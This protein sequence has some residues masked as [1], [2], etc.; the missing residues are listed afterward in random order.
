MYSLLSCQLSILGMSRQ[1]KEGYVQWYKSKCQLIKI[2]QL[3]EI[4]SKEGFPLSIATFT[5]QDTG[6]KF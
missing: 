6:S 3:G 5:L 1:V 4:I 2:S